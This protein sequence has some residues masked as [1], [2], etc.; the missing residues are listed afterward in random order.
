MAVLAGVRAVEAEE[1]LAEATGQ[2]LVRL[3]LVDLPRRQRLAVR[4]EEEVEV[5]RHPHLQVSRVYRGMYRS[6]PRTI[7]TA[8]WWIFAIRRTRFY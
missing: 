6:K 7:R 3:P 8:T 4:A 5:Q 2:R 1:A